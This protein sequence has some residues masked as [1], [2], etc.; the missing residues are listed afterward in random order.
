MVQP[1]FRATAC[2]D[3]LRRE[4]PKMVSTNF[5]IPLETVTQLTVT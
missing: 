4:V 2:I 1:N 5:T 3:Y